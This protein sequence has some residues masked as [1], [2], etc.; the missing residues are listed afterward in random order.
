MRSG[1]DKGAQTPIGARAAPS[2]DRTETYE[3]RRGRLAASLTCRALAHRPPIVG[4]RR[5]VDRA[6]LGIPF[7]L[8]NIA[9]HYSR[10]STRCDVLS[11][12]FR[13]PPY[14]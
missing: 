9:Y 3:R 4:R 5:V 8:K 7:A 6:S 14:M 1:H 11:T 12:F 10:P 2:H 13:A